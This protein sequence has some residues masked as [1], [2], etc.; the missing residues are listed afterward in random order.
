MGLFLKKFFSNFCPHIKDSKWDRKCIFINYTS[1]NRSPQQIPFQFANEKLPY[2]HC[3]AFQAMLLVLQ[4]SFQIMYNLV[5][6]IFF[7]SKKVTIFNCK[8]K[9]VIFMEFLSISLNKSNYAACAIFF[10]NIK[11]VCNHLADFKGQSAAFL[12]DH[13]IEIIFETFQTA[14]RSI[15]RIYVW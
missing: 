1:C 12:T 11:C 10:L 5:F 8:L 9:N 7:A 6:E 4:I 14:P 15:F 3:R 2:S 13:K